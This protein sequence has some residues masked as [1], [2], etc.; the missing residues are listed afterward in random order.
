L[1]L[2]YVIANAVPNVKRGKLLNVIALNS[3]QKHHFVLSIYE[4]VLISD[5]VI[6]NMQIYESVLNGVAETHRR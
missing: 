4:I 6:R 3:F 5:E 1:A 2:P